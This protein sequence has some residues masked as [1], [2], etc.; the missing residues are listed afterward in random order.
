MT[1]AISSSSRLA[2]V[3]AEGKSA[4]FSSDPRADTRPIGVGFGRDFI[5]ES[6]ADGSLEVNQNVRSPYNYVLG[7]LSRLRVTRALI[8]AIIIGLGWWLAFSTLQ[9]PQTDP[10]NVL[11]SL[12]VISL[13]IVALLGVV[14]ESPLGATPFVWAVG[15]LAAWRRSKHLNTDTS[16]SATLRRLMGSG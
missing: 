13:P 11:A 2:D 9:T 12:L 14:L 16:A 7:T 10:I 3:S 8:V 6:G 1:G 5:M 4:S 15:Q